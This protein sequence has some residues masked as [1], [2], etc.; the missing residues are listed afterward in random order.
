ML[1]VR[2]HSA[3]GD[4][5]GSGRRFQRRARQG[6]ARAV[7]CRVRVVAG[8]IVDDAALDNNVPAVVL[9]ETF[10]GCGLESENQRIHR[11]HKNFNKSFYAKSGARK[12]CKLS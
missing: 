11:K 5:K 8:Q 2:R 9:W 3:D 4:R 6:D 7:D 10:W 1:G 12:F